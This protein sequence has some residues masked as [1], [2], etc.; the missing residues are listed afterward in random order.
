[1]RVL[2]AARAAYVHDKILV[3]RNGATPVLLFPVSRS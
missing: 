3:R 1:M 2:D